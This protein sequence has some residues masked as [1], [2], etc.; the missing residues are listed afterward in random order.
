MCADAEPQIRSSAWVG[1][2]RED[3]ERGLTWREEWGE[4]WMEAQVVQGG[5]ELWTPWVHKAR[6]GRPKKRGVGRVAGTTLA[7]EGHPQRQTQ[8]RDEAQRWAEETWKRLRSDE[9]QSPTA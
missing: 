7:S 3:A 5:N 4:V 9:G 2:W 6:L 1:D 8:T